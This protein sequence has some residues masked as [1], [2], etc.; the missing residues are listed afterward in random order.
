MSDDK[1]QTLRSPQSAGGPI[2]RIS[3]YDDTIATNIQQ[4][5]R[6]NFTYTLDLTSDRDA[7]LADEP[8]VVFLEKVKKGHCQYFAGAMS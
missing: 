7:L 2:P 6:T 1:T 5:L 4:Y 3:E 8:M